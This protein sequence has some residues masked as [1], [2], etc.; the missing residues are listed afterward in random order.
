MNNNRNILTKLIDVNTPRMDAAD[1]ARLLVEQ[2]DRLPWT[3]EYKTRLFN[4]TLE[5]IRLHPQMRDKEVLPHLVEKYV[6]IL[7]NPEKEWWPSIKVI[8]AF[9]IGYDLGTEEKS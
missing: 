7:D 4:K 1:A 5:I 3:P 8:L 2:I 9:E 6:R